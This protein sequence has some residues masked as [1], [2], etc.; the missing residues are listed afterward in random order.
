[1][2]EAGDLLIIQKPDLANYLC[3]EW[4]VIAG[5]LIVLRLK[6]GAGLRIALQAGSWLPF[7]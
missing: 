6:H 7:K 4:S 5:I 3:N 2:T 1:M